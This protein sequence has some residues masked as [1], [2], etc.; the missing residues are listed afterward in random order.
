M[1]THT[2]DCGKRYDVKSFKSGIRDKGEE[3]CSCGKLIRE[4]SGGET[5]II[6]EITDKNSTQ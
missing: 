4:W 5:F 2:C 1:G 3:K 6:R